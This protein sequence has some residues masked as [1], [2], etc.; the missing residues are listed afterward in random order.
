MA[1]STKQVSLLI[2]TACLK[3]SSSILMYES[4]FAIFLS[5]LSLVFCGS[6]LAYSTMT[7]LLY[8]PLDDRLNATLWVALYLE[9]NE[10]K[11]SV[12]GICMLCSFCSAWDVR[13][14]G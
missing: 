1:A 14:V 8:C 12:G 13:V 4:L 9:L 3:A 5:N 6:F 11:G 2:S 7:I 10:T